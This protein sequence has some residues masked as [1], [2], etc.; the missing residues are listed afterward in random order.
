MWKSIMI[1]ALIC[2]GLQWFLFALCLHT[3]G[4]FSWVI[5]VQAI[6]WTLWGIYCVYRNHKF[7][8]N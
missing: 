1:I 6:V 2:A 4:R 8:K 3:Q 7:Y 5:F